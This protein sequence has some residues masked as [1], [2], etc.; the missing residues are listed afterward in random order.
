MRSPTLLYLG[1]LGRSGSTII[2][3]LLGQLPGVCSV[4]E[5]VHLWRRGIGDAERCGC[6]EPFPG[7]PFWSKVGLAA[8]GGWDNDLFRPSPGRR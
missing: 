4:G 8:F 7:C 5:V 6:G 3:R 2:E 1:G